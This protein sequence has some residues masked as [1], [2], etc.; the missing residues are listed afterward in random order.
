MAKLDIK[1]YGE[2]VL[3]KKTKYVKA[4]DD[5]LKKLVNDMFD[6]MYESNGIGL[7]A[8]QVGILR[9][10]IV[11]DTMEPGEKMALVNPKILE[12]SEEKAVMKEGCLS[13]PD[14]EGEVIRSETIKVKANDLDGNDLELDAT[15]LLAR[16]I[17]HEIDHLNGVLFVDHL[18]DTD[19]ASVS[20]KLQELAVA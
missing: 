13:I 7:A 1:I 8:P 15:G 9:K 20:R 16:V 3:R 18:N 2:E 11:V 19:K 14:V 17:Q 6:M 5:K 4:F 10:L 12:M